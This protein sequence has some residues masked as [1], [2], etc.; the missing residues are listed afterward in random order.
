MISYRIYVKHCGVTVATRDAKQSSY[1][2]QRE[3][4]VDLGWYV[5][6]DLSPLSQLCCHEQ[7]FGC[8]TFSLNLTNDMF[9]M[10]LMC[11]LFY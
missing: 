2:Q 11:H 6:L 8:L 1:P 4:H 9:T 7:K 5:D 10:C 3:H